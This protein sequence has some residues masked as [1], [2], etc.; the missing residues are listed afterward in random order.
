MS[1]VMAYDVHVDKTS[2]TELLGY[3]Y[4]L[5]QAQHNSVWESHLGL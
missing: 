4:F 3:S 1:H 5:S 2:N